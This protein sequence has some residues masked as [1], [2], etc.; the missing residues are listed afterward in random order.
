[1]PVSDNQHVAAGD[2]IARIDDRDYRNALALAE[3]QVAAAQANI[4]NI[5]AQLTVQQAQINAN[6]AQVN[7][8]QASLVFAQQ[9]ASRYQALAKTGAGTVQSAQQYSS[10]LHQQEAA[11]A[12]AQATLRLAQRQIEALKAQRASA[13][14]SLAQANAQRDQA[15]LNLSYTTVTAAQPGR[16]VNL[17][18]AIGAYVAP[19]TALAMYVPDEIWVTAN[20]KETQLKR[21][22]VNQ[23]ATIH[24]DSYDREYEGL[25]ESVAGATGARF[26]LL[27]PENATGNYVKVVQRVPVRIRFKAGQDP[28]HLLRPGMSVDPKIW[29]E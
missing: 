13:V 24:V 15:Q 23:R 28:N 19:G 10:Q 9:Q 18:A 21:M 6:E 7:Q 1:V 16:I 5:D 14:A 25:V 12:S 17:G 29:L 4:G 26:S 27:P 3:A 11:L 22:R 20:F 8:A 2:V